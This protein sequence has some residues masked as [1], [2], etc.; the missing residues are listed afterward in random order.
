MSAGHGRYKFGPFIV[1]RTAYRVLKDGE[2]LALTI[3]VIPQG[4]HTVGFEAFAE[5]YYAQN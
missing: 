4:R 3:K 2:P 5:G 1:E